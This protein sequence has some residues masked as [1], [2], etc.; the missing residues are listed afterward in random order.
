[1][2]AEQW[3]S[4]IVTSGHR[5]ETLLQVLEAWAAHVVHLY[6]DIHERSEGSWGAHDY[7]AALFIRDRVEAGLVS[8]EFRPAVVQAV[9]ALFEAFT[10]EDEA[11]LLDP[12][13]ARPDA[14]GPWWSRVPASGPVRDELDQIRKNLSQ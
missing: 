3:A 2:E 10:V 5:A 8:T 1:M 7:V 6:E 13:Q 11:M 9:D 4:H 14:G 12:V